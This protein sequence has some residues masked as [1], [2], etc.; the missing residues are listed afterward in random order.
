[1]LTTPVKTLHALQSSASHHTWSILRPAIEL[2]LAELL[3][4][5]NE[6]TPSTSSMLDNNTTANVMR[7]N[8]IGMKDL[9]GPSLPISKA[10]AIPMQTPNPRHSTGMCGHP[11]LTLRTS[12]HLIWSLTSPSSTASGMSGVANNVSTLGSR[13]DLYYQLCGSPAMMHL[14]L[15]LQIPMPLKHLMSALVT[16]TITIM[17][18]HS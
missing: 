12:T 13:C 5:C 6:E 10:G 18:H 7:D 9:T 8:D 11:S 4:S 17:M 16:V 2:P 3:G 1:M 14:P 15:Q